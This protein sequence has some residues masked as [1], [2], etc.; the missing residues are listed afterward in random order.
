MP[1][2][3]KDGY[4]PALSVTQFPRKYASS[5]SCHVPL[6]TTTDDALSLKPASAKLLTEPLTEKR[7]PL[8]LS[9]SKSVSSAAAM[10]AVT[11]AKQTASRVIFMG[12]SFP[13]RVGY[14]INIHDSTKVGTSQGAERGLGGRIFAEVVEVRQVCRRGQYPCLTHTMAAVR[15]ASIGHML[16]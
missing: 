9:C 1:M 10:V 5:Q 3:R 7:R 2:G 15:S 13:H 16:R 4:S 12:A 6:P 11:R 8:K 14:T